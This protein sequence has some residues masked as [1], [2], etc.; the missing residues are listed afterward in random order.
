MID[1]EELCYGA[2]QFSGE[3]YGGLF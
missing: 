1:S 3:M 2:T